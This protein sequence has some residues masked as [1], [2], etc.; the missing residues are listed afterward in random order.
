MSPDRTAGKRG[1]VLKL[2]LLFTKRQIHYLRLG[3]GHGRCCIPEAGQAGG[4]KG[5]QGSA[6]VK[7]EAPVRVFRAQQM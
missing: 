6:A 5:A 2:M 3:F 4:H 1:V 7:K